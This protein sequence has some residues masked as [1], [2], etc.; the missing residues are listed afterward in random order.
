MPD[1]RPP[2]PITNPGNHALSG[3]AA[4]NG[5]E[6]DY[7]DAQN[8]LAQGNLEAARSYAKRSVAAARASLPADD[9]ARLR[10][11]R[12]LAGLPAETPAPDRGR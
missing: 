9:P 6:S 3:T 1:A 2:Y 10:Y 7:Q 11:E 5:Y 12:F 8:E 4:A